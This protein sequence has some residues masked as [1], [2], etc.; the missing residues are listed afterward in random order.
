MLSLTLS[1]STVLSILLCCLVAHHFLFFL[2]HGNSQD[3]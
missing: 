3:C 1:R 2:G